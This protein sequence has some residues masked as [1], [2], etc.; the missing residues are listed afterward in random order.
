MNHFEAHYGYKPPHGGLVTQVPVTVE[1]LHQYI[2]ERQ[3]MNQRIKAH[4][5]VATNIMKQLSDKGKSE[6]IFSI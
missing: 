1:S 3:V 2:G 5:D 6:R 4:L